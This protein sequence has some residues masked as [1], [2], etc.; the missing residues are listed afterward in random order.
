LTAIEESELDEECD[1]NEIGA[2]FIQ[3]AD[4]GFCSAASGE[5]VVHE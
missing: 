3:Q 5:E 2:E 4:G 1:A